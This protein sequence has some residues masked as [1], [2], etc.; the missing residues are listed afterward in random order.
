MGRSAK[1]GVRA[2]CGCS[3]GEGGGGILFQ[4]MVTIHPTWFSFGSGVGLGGEGERLRNSL[5]D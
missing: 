3:F 1:L 2:E 4:D 5:A